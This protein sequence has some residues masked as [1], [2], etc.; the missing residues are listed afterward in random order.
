[1]RKV[2]LSLL[3]ISFFI[4]NLSGCEADTRKPP[5]VYFSADAVITDSDITMNAKLSSTYGENIF[6][7]IISPDTLKGLEY[8]KTNSTLYIRYGELECIADED[9]LASFSALDVLIDTLASLQTNQFSYYKTEQH[10]DVY[11][12]KLKNVDCKVFVNPQ[13]GFI[14]KIVPQYKDVSIVLENIKL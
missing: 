7:S 11:K 12:V 6:V 10:L 2:L 1:M 3:A 8:Q 5:Q 13:N 4:F 14:T 9:Y